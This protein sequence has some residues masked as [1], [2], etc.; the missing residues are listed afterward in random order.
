[1]ILLFLISILWLGC[2]DKSNF[3]VD[4][5]K[6]RQYKPNILFTNYRLLDCPQQILFKTKTELDENGNEIT[7]S[8]LEA[9][10][11]EG[12]VSLIEGKENSIQWLDTKYSLPKIEPVFISNKKE[13]SIITVG[14]VIKW[15]SQNSNQEILLAIR[16]GSEYC[17]KKGKKGQIFGTL[18]ILIQDKGEY[19]LKE[20][21][22][23]KFDSDMP[24]EIFLKR[25][26]NIM[27]KNKSEDV[28]VSSIAYTSLQS[29]IL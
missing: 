21:D 11:D 6:I 2:N 16:P 24:V 29:K 5:E 12:M 1:M 7:T 25:G 26:E 14:S 18:P 27:V 8:N 10:V 3:S 19:Q 17:G 4:K 22:I 20:Q 23:Q 28:C 9:N 13:L 15:N